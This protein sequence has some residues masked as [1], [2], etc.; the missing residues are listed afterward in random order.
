M[1]RRLTVSW[2]DPA[3]FADR[4][5]APIRLLAVSD[6]AD[7]ALDHAGNRDALG[8]IDAILGCGDLEP[9]YLAF[10]GDAFGVPVAFVRGNHD[11]GGQWSSTS[12]PAPEHLPSGRLVDIDGLCVAPLE[13]PGLRRARAPRDEWQ[14]W[15]DVLRA[16]SDLGTRRLLGRSGPVLVLS[17]APP[18]GVGD[19]AADRYHLG[20]RAYRW[21]LERAC[22]PLWLHGHTTPASV[23]DWQTSF[24]RSKVA[25]VT[26]S[27]LVELRAPGNAEGS[28]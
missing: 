3:P 17:H 4:A 14:A 13:W 22:P 24:G 15:L 23:A 27:V 25:N 8:P 9:A 20:Y 1:T 5:G 18:R 19:V 7:P 16:R 11:R 21:L 12:T 26:G 28:G 6:C 2:P 10:L